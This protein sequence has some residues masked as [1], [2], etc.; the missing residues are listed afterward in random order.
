MRLASLSV[1]ILLASCAAPVSVPGG[2]EVCV[3]GTELTWSNFGKPMLSTWCV[4]CHGA[5]EPE[6][7][8]RLDSARPRV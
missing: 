6:S 2:A 7:E 8:L 3:D 4:S 5:K 1:L